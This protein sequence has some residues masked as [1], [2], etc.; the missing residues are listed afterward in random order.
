M[1]EMSVVGARWEIRS[2]VQ[3]GGQLQ[4]SK[5]QSLAEKEVPPHEGESSVITRVQE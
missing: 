1:E 3:T 5:A 4:G 2:P